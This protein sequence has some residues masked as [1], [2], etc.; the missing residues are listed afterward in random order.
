ML[1]T[2]CFHSLGPTIFFSLCSLFPNFDEM[3]HS[4]ERHA[5]FSFLGLSSP[6]SK[7]LGVFV[8]PFVPSSGALKCLPR[9]LGWKMANSITLSWGMAMCWLHIQ[10]PL[11]LECSH[12]ITGCPC[13]T[14][15]PTF[16]SIF[17]MHITSFIN[18]F[19]FDF[20]PQSGGAQ[21]LILTLYSGFSPGG[22]QGNQLYVVPGNEPGLGTC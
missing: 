11:S 10:I 13:K 20:D 21:D 7:P 18:A 8:C 16:P 5:G 17:S 1:E 12:L 4:L 14:L 19:A 6:S 2:C 15:T 3:L 9:R 22:A